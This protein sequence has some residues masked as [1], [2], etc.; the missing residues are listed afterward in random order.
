MKKII[1][2]ILIILI[3]SNIVNA[4]T[5]TFI[6]EYTYQAS[7]EDSL[8]SSR[9]ITLA[10]VKVL[11]LEE[12]GTYLESET[13]VKNFQMTKDKITAITGGILQTK[14]LEE[15]WNGKEYWLRAKITL[16]PKDIYNNIDN[17]RKDREKIKELEELKKKSEALLAENDRLSK[18]LSQAVNNSSEKREIVKEIK[19][20]ISKLSADEWFNKGNHEPDKLKAIKYYSKAIEL[21]PNDVA[22]YINR[23][24]RYDEIGETQKA[25]NDY[26]KSLELNPNYSEG[27]NNLAIMYCKERDY[28][29]ALKYFEKALYLNPDDQIIK[30]NIKMLK[31]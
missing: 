10:K 7:E 17:L 22:F 12:I 23:G 24:N 18:A 13:E 19:N 3:S 9:T 15:K 1:F 16:N 30:K 28:N 8:G 4:E 5:K 20:N 29:T 25:I 14:I 11:M 2:L 6:K 26:K 31:E 21:N 27:L